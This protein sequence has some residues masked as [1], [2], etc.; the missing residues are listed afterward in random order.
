V[1]GAVRRGDAERGTQG[2]TVK[3]PFDASSIISAPWFTAWQRAAADAV[4]AAVRDPRLIQFSSSMLRAQLLTARVWQ[5]GLDASFAAF[6]ALVK[7]SDR[8]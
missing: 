5:T 1:D 8:A 7:K 3:A 2:L 4:A 6:E